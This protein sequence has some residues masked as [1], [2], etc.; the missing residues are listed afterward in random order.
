MK[1]NI[2]NARVNQF[3]KIMIQYSINLIHSKKILIVELYIIFSLLT[4]R[5]IM[6][7]PGVPTNSLWA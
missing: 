1:K 5:S 6:D 2:E 7:V 4:S 3:S